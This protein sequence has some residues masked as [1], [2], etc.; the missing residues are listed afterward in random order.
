MNQP[1]PLFSSSRDFRVWRYDVEHSELVLRTDDNPDEPVE[2]LFECVLSLHFD[3]LWF[4]GLVV[5][6]AEDAIL[7]S[8]TVDIP[9][10]KIELGTTGHTGHVVCRRLTCVG[11]TH[12]DGKVLWTVTA[13]RPR[14]RRH[15]EI[16][17][18]ER[19]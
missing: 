8:P 6:R 1:E 11:G 16:P 9:H 13:G 3:Q 19:A 14:S 7:Q 4:T 2:L 5:G 18:V 17:A 12:P 15:P 10:L